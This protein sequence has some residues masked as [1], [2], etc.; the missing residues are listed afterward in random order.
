MT[1]PQPSPTSTTLD[2]PSSSSSSSSPSQCAGS[3]CC[4]SESAPSAP[5][6]SDDATNETPNKSASNES[7]SSG[8]AYENVIGQSGKL[9]ALIV[10]PTAH[11]DHRGTVRETY[12]ASW[13]PYL[14]AIQQLV[15]SNSK[16][17]TLRGMHL[18]RKQWDIWRFVEDGALVRLVNHVNGDEGFI[19]ADKDVV[20][21]IPPGISHGFYTE[22]GCI[23]VYALTEEYTGTD[24]FGWY[25]FD[26]PEQRREGR[27]IA[28]PAWTWPRSHDGLNISER[29]LR[30]PRLSEFEG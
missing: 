28:G 6:A 21:A 16:P 30:A 5:I 12:R 7:T 14:P 25:P 13:F 9:L 19:Q 22:R 24:E 27:V 20:L 29:D 2:R 26:V 18:H 11:P 23:L 10:R 15:Q 8:S 4:Q 17:K 1:Q 3:Q